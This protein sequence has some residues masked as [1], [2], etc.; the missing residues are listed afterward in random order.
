MEYTTFGR[1]DLKVSVIGL[2]CGGFSRLGRRSGRSENESIALVQQALDMG[3]NFIDTARA[4]DT[5]SIVGKAIKGYDLDDIV[6]STKAQIDHGDQP[7]SATQVVADLDKSLRQLD[8]D[9]IDIFHLHGVQPHYYDYAKEHIV[10][11]LLQQRDKGKFRFLGITESPPRDPHHQS[12][13]AALQD[14][15]FAAFMVAFHMLHQSARTQILQPAQERGIGTLIMFAVRVIFSSLK[16]LRQAI[17]AQIESGT[18]PAWLA[19]KDQPLD[20]LI[21]PEGARSLTD[22]AYRYCRHEPGADV[23]LVGTGDKDHLSANIKSILSPPLPAADLERL[24]TLF[25]H[26]QNVGLDAPGA[27]PANSTVEKKS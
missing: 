7:Q 18:L 8:I 5:E 22:A 1:T 2:G 23:V 9:C 6:I 13:Q 27:T 25:G 17:A 24:H 10:P 4:Y 26:L 12:L 19:T 14:D 21:H 11:A 3:I 16:H 15:C 20:F